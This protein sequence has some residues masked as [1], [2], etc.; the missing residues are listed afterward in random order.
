MGIR[1]I[2]IKILFQIQSRSE[3][4]LVFDVWSA[5]LSLSHIT[6]AFEVNTYIL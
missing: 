6:Y 4:G 3:K 2:K 5:I 1:G